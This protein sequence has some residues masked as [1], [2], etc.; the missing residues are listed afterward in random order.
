MGLAPIIVEGLMPVLRRVAT[1][2]K[3]AIVL[4]EQHVRLALEVADQAVVVV[5]GEIRLR[6]DATTLSADPAAL[7]AAYLSDLPV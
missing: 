2:T 6:G 1:E 3:A 4:V 7:E 5:H